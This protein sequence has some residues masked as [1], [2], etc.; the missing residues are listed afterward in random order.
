MRPVT[1]VAPQGGEGGEG[2]APASMVVRRRIEWVD[3]DASG[4]WHNTAV[5]R[6]V[7]AG[8]TALLE[9]LGILDAIYR[10]AKAPRV[11][12]EAD[13]ARPCYPGDRVEVHTE[14]VGM[15]TTS[16]RYRSTISRGGEVCA[17]A[18]MVCVYQHAGTPAPWPA[19]L[20]R[21]LLGAG[22]QLPELAPDGQDR[23]RN[24]PQG[25]SR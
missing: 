17:I 6:L 16:L 5:F 19:E 7:E 15:G 1:S 9:R 23:V 12:I 4:H 3:T 24:E 10:G 14:V 22:P 8:E 21:V 13:F 11:H 25:P 18:A 20:R 2:G